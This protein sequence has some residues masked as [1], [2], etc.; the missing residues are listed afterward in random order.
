MSNSPCRRGN[1]YCVII[2][3]MDYHVS[4]ILESYQPL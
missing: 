3:Q 2:I 1:M 4:N